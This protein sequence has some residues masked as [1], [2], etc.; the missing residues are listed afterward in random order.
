MSPLGQTGA[1]I[2][3]YFDHGSIYEDLQLQWFLTGQLEWAQLHGVHGLSIRA[4][5]CCGGKQR[6]RHPLAAST[7]PRRHRRRV[8]TRL[9]QAQG[10]PMAPIDLL[11]TLV[12]DELA[13]RPIACSNA[14]ANKMRGGTHLHPGSHDEP[15]G[16]RLNELNEAG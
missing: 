10:E 11:S 5:A 8:G 13:R 12:S 4:R 14:G 3:K 15:P 1:A 7:T 6:P 2:S 16:Q 9:Q